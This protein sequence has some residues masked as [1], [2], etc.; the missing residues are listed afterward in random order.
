MRP[1]PIKII[2]KNSQKNLDHLD[3]STNCS[4][5]LVF[6]IIENLNFQE[7]IKLNLIK[8][9]FHKNVTHILKT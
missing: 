1:K 8:N 9:Y 2:W 6:K 7:Q 3:I 4:Q 5:D